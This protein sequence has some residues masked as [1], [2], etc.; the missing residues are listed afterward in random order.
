MSVGIVRYP[1]S[2]CDYDCLSFFADSFFIWHK[3]ETKPEEFYDKLN[4]L[5]IPG[6]F[7]FG[8]RDYTSATGEFTHLPGIQAIKSPVTN[9]IFE[10]HKRNIPIL[11][12]CNGFQILI[13]LKLLPGCLLKNNC[14]KFQ[15][16]SISCIL[17]SKIF[18]ICKEIKIP[19][20]NSFGNYQVSYDL[21]SKMTKN[22]QIFL[23]YK[24]FD[25]GSYDNIAGICNDDH[26][27]FGIMPHPERIQNNLD[28][29]FFKILFNNLIEY[30]KS[31]NE[32]VI[33]ECIIIVD[34]HVSYKRQKFF[35]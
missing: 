35:I 6:G 17:D 27:V 16:E 28:R 8:D 14:N 15:S 10:V 32:S 4:L 30:K 12:I 11:G 29:L 18:N 22:N 26:N 2:N 7:A 21:Y 31:Y 24:D 20:A 34:E 23:K 3:E 33:K 1:G 13:H 19:I 25:N 9:I 5:V